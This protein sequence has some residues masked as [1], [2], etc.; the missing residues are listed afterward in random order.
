MS[1][2]RYYELRTYSFDS[3]AQRSLFASFVEKALIPAY[4]R[5]GIET[6]GAFTGIYGPSSAELLLVIP[7]D[8][9][10]SVVDAS[11]RLLADREFADAGRGILDTD[12]DHP[13]FQRFESRL[14]RAF[15][16]MPDIE[17]PE[18]ETADANRIFEIRIYESHSLLA[19]A[20]KR[21][22][23][24]EGGEIEIFRK[25]GLA[26]V[27]FGETI[28][29]PRMPSLLYMLTFEDMSHRDQAW[30]AF[31][32]DPDWKALRDDPQY[33][34]TVSTITDLIL[35]PEPYSQM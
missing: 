32:T 11:D 33:A 28:A 3:G 14:L 2:R 35:A 29:G 10:D 31:K 13:S 23:F 9:P 25:T 27:L 12:L 30:D 17:L 22:M 18:R 20:K 1:T 19:A 4:A 26:P 7:H 15:E 24:N 21:E 8:G 6:I 16:E 34:D 5:M